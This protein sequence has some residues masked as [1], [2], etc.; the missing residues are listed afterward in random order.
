MAVVLLIF[1]FAVDADAP[2]TFVGYL[3]RVSIIRSAG[4][5]QSLAR[6]VAARVEA[7]PAVERVIPVAPQ[8]SV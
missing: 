1:A 7:H 5:F 8:Y 3:S 2:E 6:D 4:I